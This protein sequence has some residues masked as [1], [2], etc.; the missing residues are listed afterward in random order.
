MHESFTYS[1]TC[2]RG[3]NPIYRYTNGIGTLSPLIIEYSRLQSL[4]TGKVLM[5]Y[6]YF[7]SN[8]DVSSKNYKDK[9][10][11]IIIKFVSNIIYT[12]SIIANSCIDTTYIVREPKKVKLAFPVQ[13]FEVWNLMRYFL[14]AKNSN[15]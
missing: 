14:E 9:I 6:S 4:I 5:Q 10:E 8:I 2:S 1:R 15:S 13:K 11:Y 3:L 7:S 12:L